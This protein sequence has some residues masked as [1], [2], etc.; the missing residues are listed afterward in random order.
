MDYLLNYIYL[1]LYKLDKKKNIKVYWISQGKITYHFYYKKKLI[2][3]GKEEKIYIY[4][5]LRAIF[6]SII[7]FIIFLIL[8][9][10]N[11]CLIPVGYLI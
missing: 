4:I 1:L 10:Y 8:Y 7:T 6:S 5:N 2:Y 9:K 3:K 11:I